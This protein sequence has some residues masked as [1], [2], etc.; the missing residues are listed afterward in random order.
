MEYS[1]VIPIYNEEKAV[2]LLCKQIK[3]TMDKI[4]PNENYEIIFVDDGSTDTSL[5][6]LK[7]M[8]PQIKELIILSLDKNY[9]Q[10]CALQ[11][12]FDASSGNV[13]I[14]LDGDLQNNP[15]DIP[16]LLDKMNEGYDVVCGWCKNKH[17]KR[18]KAVASY[19]A[20]CIRRLVF[21]E[22]IHDVGSMLRTY[23]RNSLEGI[24]LDGCKHRFLT[25]I[26]AKKG[27]KIGEVE[28][29]A[30]PRLYGVSKYGIIDRIIKSIPEIFRI[31]LL[32]DN[33]SLHK[34]KYKIK[35]IVR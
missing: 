29:N 35:E 25:K 7:E 1:V 13:I 20:N 23:T 15:K 24:N 28:I 10:S 33:G 9:G 17:T 30:Y 31:Y 21:K 26:L 22:K 8:M 12:G 16:K 18:P 14:T 34:R 32:K 11:A 3:E 27:A 19:I 6:N 5:Y 2:N 4:I